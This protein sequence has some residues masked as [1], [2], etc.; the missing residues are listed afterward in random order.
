MEDNGDQKVTKESPVKQPNSPTGP[1]QPVN[2]KV[3]DSGSVPESAKN[4]RSA[5]KEAADN[6]P[7]SLPLN[8]GML[9]NLSMNLE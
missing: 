4:E 9:N 1:S 6:L 2:G 8:L 7:T 3:A 5:E